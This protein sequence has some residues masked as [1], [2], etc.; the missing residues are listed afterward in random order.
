[1][2]YPLVQWGKIARFPSEINLY[3]I[4][5]MGIRNSFDYNFFPLCLRAVDYSVRLTNSFSNKIFI[6]KKKEKN[7]RNQKPKPNS[8][9]T[10]SLVYNQAKMKHRK[11]FLTTRIKDVSITL[12]HLTNFDWSNF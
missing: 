10:L 1:M 6:S 9:E 8:K 12:N 2:L 7:V 3:N 4:W 5:K 11:I